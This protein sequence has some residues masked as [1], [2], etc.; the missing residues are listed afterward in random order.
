[1]GKKILRFTGETVYKRKR[2][3]LAETYYQ[4]ML[5]CILTRRII[6]GNIFYV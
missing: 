3:A 4:P 1:M 2:S 5:E 6:I